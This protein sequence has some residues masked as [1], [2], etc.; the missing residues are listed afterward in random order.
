MLHLVCFPNTHHQNDD[1]ERK[2]YFFLSM[3]IRIYL[4]ET[5]DWTEINDVCVVVFY[6]LLINI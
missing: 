5:L 3:T 1:Q 6:V 4:G 2:L